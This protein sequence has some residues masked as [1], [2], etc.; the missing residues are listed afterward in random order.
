M[1]EP[2][3]EI[4]DEQVLESL[5]FPS[6]EAWAEYWPTVARRARFRDANDF[7]GTREDAIATLLPDRN[8]ILGAAER[9]MRH[10][11]QGWGDVSIQHGPVVDF[12]AP[13]GE[14]GKYGFHY[15]EWAKPLVRAHLLTG[16]QRYVAEFDALFDAWYAQRDRIVGR[17]KGIDVIWY[18]LG[19]GFRVRTF[20][21]NY[22]L[23]NP[24]RTLGTHERM[25]KTLLGAGR[26]LYDEQRRE[27]R[28][29]NWQIIGSCG[30]AMIGLLVPEFREAREWARLGIERLAEHAE[31]DFFDDGC[32]SERCP[33]SYMLVAYRDIANAAKLSNDERLLQP[34]ERMRG[35]FAQT[36]PPDRFLP[37]IND[38]SRAPIPIDVAPVEHSV[39]LPA[40]GFTVMRSGQTYML[41]NHGSY[42]DG[43]THDDALSFQLHAFGWP[44]AIDSGIGLTYDDPLHRTWYVTP[45]A[46]NM[47]TVDGVAIDRRAAEGK[48]V[49][50]QSDARLDYF[51]AT[52]HGYAAAG[53]V[54]RRQV[55]F[56]KPDYFIVYDV[57]RADAE[58]SLTWHLHTTGPGLHVAESDEVSWSRTRGKGMASV[59]GIA[60]FDA[61]HAEVDWM[62]LRSSVSPGGTKA[63]AV[64]LYAFES[65]PPNV[66]FRATADGEF[67]VEHNGVID[68]VRIGDQC[69][70]RR[71]RQS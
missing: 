47:L 43:H 52:H 30:L 67:V 31:R 8:E 50:W 4:T 27:Y 25:L 12:D 68:H 14:M 42:A 56:V 64:L 51:A 46:H 11:I 10:D 71:T 3:Q 61:A 58:R 69:T 16:E 5:Q 18:E 57:V 39:S 20:L 45:E 26:W 21:E 36:L 66:R 41:I 44:L 65:A 9:V 54:H 29:G 35:W 22:Y 34:L 53:I 23:P 15:W 49:I 38:G 55:M 24:Q 60:G 13:Y 37:A 40:S 32:H 33:S 17:H 62:R 70:L 48:E 1:T 63:L 59:A 28:R 2:V 7:L 19:L 6:Y